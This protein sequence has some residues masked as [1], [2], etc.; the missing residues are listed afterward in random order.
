MERW[1]NF[2]EQRN[3]VLNRKVETL[4]REC[5]DYLAL[6]LKSAET[7]GSERETLERQ[8]AGEKEALNGFHSF[9][10]PEQCDPMPKDARYLVGHLFWR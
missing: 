7:V 9:Y 2:Q 10:E 3:A 8:V 5:H 1:R 4:L 6:A